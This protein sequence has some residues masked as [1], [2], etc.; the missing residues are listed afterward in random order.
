[1]FALCSI[2]SEQEAIRSATQFAREHPRSGLGAFA[3]R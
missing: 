2:G 1:V 3:V